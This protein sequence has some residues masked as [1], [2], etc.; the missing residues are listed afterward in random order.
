MTRITPTPSTALGRSA[1]ATR[2]AACCALGS[3]F[4][5]EAWVCDVARVFLRSRA[6]VRLRRAAGSCKTP[7]NQAEERFH[8][9]LRWAREKSSAVFR[10]QECGAGG[11]RTSPQ[12]VHKTTC[13]RTP[14]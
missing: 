7:K 4:I 3:H 1:K 14:R 9:E 13:P 11:S 12:L 2:R 8:H 10:R 6:R 5:G